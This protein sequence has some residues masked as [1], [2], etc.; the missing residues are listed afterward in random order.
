MAEASWRLFE[1]LLRRTHLSAPSDVRAVIAQQARVIGAESLE[2]CV[3]D[4]EQEMLIPVHTD[5]AVAPEPLSV[6]EVAAVSAGLLPFIG[7]VGGVSVRLGRGL[8]EG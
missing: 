7:S 2:L 1:G 5:A 8:I 6:R 4:Y 3:A